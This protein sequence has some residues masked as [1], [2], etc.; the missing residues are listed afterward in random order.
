LTVGDGK[1]GVPPD[2]LPDVQELG[3]PDRRGP[4]LE[5]FAQFSFAS[6]GIAHAVYHAGRR[7]DPAVLVL[8]E[9]PGIAPGLLQ[10]GGRLVEDGFQIYLPWLFG[11]VQR[12]TPL[13]NFARLCISREFAGL[14]T[15]VSAPVTQWLRGLVSHVSAH[16]GGGPVGALGMCVTGGFVIP[17]LLEPKVSV[18][19]AAQPAIPV[20]LAWL[21]LGRAGTPAQAALNV[22]QADLDSARIRLDAGEVRLLAVRCAADRL[23][24]PGRLEQ[25]AAQFPIGLTIR[26]YGKGTDRNAWG[27]RP[28]ATY[29]KE[30]RLAAA[31]LAPADHPARRAYAQLVAFL[32]HGLVE[33]VGR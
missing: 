18:A 7:A 6:G 27:E 8:H 31:E 32:R 20:S 30:Y 17:L 9:L 16:N 14:R 4:P 15:G 25:L 3:V 22:S 21:A 28:H 33:Q 11:A 12:R 2:A 19:V 29:T 26:T 1:I 13:R 24:P 10:L 5:G 23:C